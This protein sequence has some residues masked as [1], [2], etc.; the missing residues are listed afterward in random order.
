VIVY[1]FP[2]LVFY[3][4]H[5]FKGFD[6]GIKLLILL[7]SKGLAFSLEPSKVSSSRDVH[8]TTRSSR[9]YLA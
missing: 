2:G 4:G 7:A 1:S 9:S 5:F 8:S 3:L 6:L